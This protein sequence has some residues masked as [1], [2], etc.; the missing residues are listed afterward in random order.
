MNQPFDPMTGNIRA[1]PD[2]AASM[3]ERFA[4][5]FT[6]GTSS[7]LAAGGKIWC[8]RSCANCCSLT[9][10][11]TL[12]E[13]LLIAP[14]LDSRQ[15]TA[16]ATRAE[17]LRHIAD[18]AADLKEFWQRHR[19]EAGHCPLLNDEGA[20]SIYPVRPFACRA[21]LSTRDPAWCGID[22]ATLTSLE[23]QLYLNSLDPTI[24]TYP[25]H[26]LA[27]PQE[28]AAALERELLEAMHSICGCSLSGC[29]PVLLH[30]AAGHRLT[31]AL[32]R[33]P[34]AVRQLLVA[35]GFDHPF[36]V[37]FA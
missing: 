20:C 29:L 25:T 27:A 31:V 14:S 23:R 30:L 28:A 22:F 33:G 34:E 19:R 10:H 32:R 9:V 26:Y 8:A 11:L 1:L 2:L 36:L 6:S 5:I 35:A 12:P 7:Y 3:Q 21:L 13:A 37:N 18:T 17:E 16:V 15:M 4:E 24:V